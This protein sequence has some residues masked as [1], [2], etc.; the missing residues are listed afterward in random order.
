MFKLS[1]SNAKVKDAGYG[2]EVNGK[3]L[4]DIIS[5]MLGTKVGSSY[6]YNSGL[7][8]FESNC[9]NITV[10]IDPQPVTTKID[11]GE[12]TWCSV[13]DMEEDKNGQYRQKDEAA[14]TEE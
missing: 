7:P 12:E 6:G 11:T 8:T 14:E 5:T 10:I 13:E 9:C 2:L 4:S 1:F 3:A